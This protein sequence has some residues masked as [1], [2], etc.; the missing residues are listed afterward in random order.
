MIRRALETRR[1]G[2]ALR[3]F[4]DK[5]GLLYFGSVDHRHDEHDVIRGLTVSTS[6]R[7]A[8][9][10]NGSFDG[11][12]V[13]I[14]DRYDTAGLG[15]R[16]VRHNWCIV[17]VTLRSTQNIPDI[18]L[19]PTHTTAKFH[20]SFTG[21]R[22]IQPIHELVHNPY[23]PELLQRYHILAHVNK[24]QEVNQII[25]PALGNVLAVRFWP[26]AIEIRGGKL[27]VY[28]TEHR[29]SETVLGS[30]VESA[31]WLADSIDQQEN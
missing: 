12:D 11:Y 20:H 16:A 15:K 28:I 23:T 5:I 8:H 2:K 9:Y 31:L 21:L 30:A 3:R 26:H 24:A 29:L 22:H 7:D 19:L 13:A 4:A 25:S 14:V 27:F 10:A 6:H 18:F 1:R 17:Q